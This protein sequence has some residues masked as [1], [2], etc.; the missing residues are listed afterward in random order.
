MFLYLSGGK[1]ISSAR[2]Q[3]LRHRTINCCCSDWMTNFDR[4]NCKRQ[5]SSA[6]ALTAFL[7]H[8][9]Q[10]LHRNLSRLIPR[11]AATTRNIVE[12]RRKNRNTKSRNT[13]NQN[14]STNIITS[15]DAR[16]LLLCTI[17]IYLHILLKQFGEEPSLIAQNRFSYLWNFQVLQLGDPVQRSVQLSWFVPSI[18][19]SC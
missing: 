7:P 3:V 17:G 15:T 10:A 8:P 11:A 16:R 19:F 9:V 14:T 12:E 13:R 18:L 4:R 2:V 6:I 1:M 5:L